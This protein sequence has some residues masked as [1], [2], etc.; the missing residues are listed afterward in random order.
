MTDDR[1]VGPKLP[2]WTAPPVPD[3]VPLE[4]RYVRLEA[5][6][7]DRHAAILFKAFDGHHHVWDYMPVGPFASAAQFHR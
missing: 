4:G 6:D 5:L 3:M 1:P 2:D 7:A